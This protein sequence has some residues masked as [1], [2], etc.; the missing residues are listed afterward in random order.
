[1]QWRL[2]LLLPS[3]DGVGAFLDEEGGRE[4]VTPHD[5]QV[6]QAVAL[7][8]QQVQV[9]VVRDQRVGNLLVAA[10]QRQ[11]QGEI[12]LIVILIQLQRELKIKEKKNRGVK[13]QSGVK[14]SKGT[15]L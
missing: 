11:V 6:Q 8:V 10:E 3:Q 15:C 1:M 7:R 2:L 12:P 4:G 9:A 13:G 5:G 14:G